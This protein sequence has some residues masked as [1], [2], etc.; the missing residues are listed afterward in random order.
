MIRK[1][2]VVPE[3]TN[4]FATSIALSGIAE[5]I[6]ACCFACGDTASRRDIR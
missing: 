2:S 6:P 1:S 4:S 3:H 5:A